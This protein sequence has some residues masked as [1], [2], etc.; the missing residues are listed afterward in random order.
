MNNILSFQ[1]KKLNHI[2]I[3]PQYVPIKCKNKLCIDL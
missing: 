2:S 3:N 1:S